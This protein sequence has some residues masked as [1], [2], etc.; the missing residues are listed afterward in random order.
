MIA[1]K[2]SGGVDDLI[3]D[4]TIFAESSKVPSQ[5]AEAGR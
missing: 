4:L 3:G 2:F 5:K 1:R